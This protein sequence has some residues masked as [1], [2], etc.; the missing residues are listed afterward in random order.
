MINFKQL[1]KSF[2]HAGQGLVY[3]V[4]AEQNLKIQLI[5]ASLVLLLTI[6]LPL[7]YL[8]IALLVLV[9]ALVLIL[10]LLNTI[11]ERL[12][13]LLKPRMHDYVK[14]IK[15]IMAAVVLVASIAAVLIGLLIFLP[16]LT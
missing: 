8:E 14:V 15:D 1:S 10:E 12:L 11:L 13:D 3:V 7:K 2:K 16:H 9:I 6:I 5:I 4:R